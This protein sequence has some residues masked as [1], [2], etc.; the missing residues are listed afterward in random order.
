MLICTTECLVSVDGHNR[1]SVEA[2]GGMSERTLE[3]DAAPQPCTA[4]HNLVRYRLLPFSMPK[5]DPMALLCRR[6]QESDEAALK[7]IFHRM[8]QRLMAYVRSMVG[9][10]VAAHDIVQDVFASLWEMRTGLDPSQSLEAL[11]YRM[12]RNRTY[13][14]KRNRQNRIRKQ[15]AVAEHAQ[16]GAPSVLGSNPEEKIDADGLERRIHTWIEA[17]PD[18]QKE[19]LTLSRQHG[20]SHKEVAHAME[21]SPRTVNNHIVRALNTLQEKVEAYDPS[22]LQSWNR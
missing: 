17:L 8:R 4:L 20:L 5:P 15:E 3:G 21:I 7:V 14:Y 13:T 16:R 18:R 11:L 2:V 12:T 10:D 1:R 19:A 9:G 22:L 6:L